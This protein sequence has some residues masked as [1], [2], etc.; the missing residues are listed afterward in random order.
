MTARALPVPGPGRP[1]K[2][3]R[4]ASLAVFLVYRSCR[5]RRAATPLAFTTTLIAS[6]MR[7]LA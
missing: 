3:S 1:R 2:G 5:T 4:R 6:S 7:S